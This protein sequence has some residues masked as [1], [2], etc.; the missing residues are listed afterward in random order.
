MSVTLGK[1]GRQKMVFKP[2]IE[3]TKTDD[4]EADLVR[5]TANFSKSLE[6]FIRQNP[7]Q[8]VWMHERWKTRPEGEKENP[9]SINILS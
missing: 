3:V 8:W 6:D 9:N 5:N 4:Y 7:T 1:D 2:E